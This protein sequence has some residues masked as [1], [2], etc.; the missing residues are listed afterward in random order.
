MKLLLTSSGFYNERVKQDFLKLVETGVSEAKV[1]IITT[2]SPFKEQNKYA[3]KAKEDFVEMGFRHINFIDLEFES[4]DRLKEKDVIFIN[5]GNPF[6]LLYHTKKSGADKVFSE[7][8]SKNVVIVGVSA[9]AL[10]LGPNIKVVHYF[11]PNINVFG[12]Y[13]FTAL[14]LTDILIFPHFDREDIFKD[15]TGKPIE[16]RLKEFERIANCEM[17]R[18][19]D[20]D[21][22]IIETKINE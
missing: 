19:K 5:G 17:T 7:L 13:D 18:L 15:L 12:M 2:A 4:P 8:S 16:D 1:T 9:G 20:E 6:K 11:T 22:L 21:Y 14:N 3:Q 10:L